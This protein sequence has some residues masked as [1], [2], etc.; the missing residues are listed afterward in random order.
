MFE[1]YNSGTRMDATT[2]SAASNLKGY[3]T[4]EDSNGNDSSGQSAGNFTISGQA[5]GKEENFT[6]IKQYSELPLKIVYTAVCEYST[7]K[8]TCSNSGWYRVIFADPIFSFK[9]P[10]YVI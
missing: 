10:S 2:H 7:F 3:Y 5:N 4:F 1:L 8:G 9:S 6:I